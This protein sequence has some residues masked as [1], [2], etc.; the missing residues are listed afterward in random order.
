MVVFPAPSRPIM[1]SRY[2]RPDH[3]LAKTEDKRF[4][5]PKVVQAQCL[6]PSYPLVFECEEW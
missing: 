4:P 2:S 1:S 6:G 3:S 5:T